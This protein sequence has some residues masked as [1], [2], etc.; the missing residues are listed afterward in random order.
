[1]PR[2]VRFSLGGKKTPPSTA[3]TTAPTTAGAR[4]RGDPAVPAVGSLSDVRSA[5]DSGLATT[6]DDEEELEEEEEELVDDDDEV[7]VDDEEDEEEEDPLAG[8]I[9]DDDDDNNA[10]DE[11]KSRKLEAAARRREQAI[12]KKREANASAIAKIMSGDSSI[13]RK[14]ELAE[15]EAEERRKRR[16]LDGAL[17]P[18]Y[19]RLRQRADGTRML[20]TGSGDGGGG[21][22]W[23]YGQCASFVGTKKT[24]N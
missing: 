7:L 8:D 2:T 17:A 4:A 16:V 1:M 5:G 22:L 19:V 21:A 10:A 14:R 23:A 20:A 24:S 18:G 6:A 9:D 13:R 11:R 12:Q 3:A 15:A